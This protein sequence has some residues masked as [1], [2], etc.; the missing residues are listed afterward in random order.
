MNTIWFF[1]SGQSTDTEQQVQTDLQRKFD[2]DDFLMGKVLVKKP[3]HDKD[4]Y[5]IELEIVE[6]VLL[7]RLYRHVCEFRAARGEQ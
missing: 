3:R 6:P 1:V 7:D 5:C 2:D 4:R